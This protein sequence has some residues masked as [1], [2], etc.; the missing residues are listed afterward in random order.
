MTETVLLNYEKYHET[1]KI[2][3]KVLTKHFFSAMIWAS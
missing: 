3:K 2:A 1:T